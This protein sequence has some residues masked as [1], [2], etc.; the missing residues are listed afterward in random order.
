MGPA[1]CFGFN[2]HQPDDGG[3]SRNRSSGKEQW[4][5]SA[6][7]AWGFASSARSKNCGKGQGLSPISNDAKSK[8][9]PPERT[10]KP[11][12]AILP[13]AGQ[14]NAE[15]LAY[16]IVED[17]ITG[18]TQYRWLSVIARS[19]SCAHKGWTLDIRKVGRELGAHYVLEGSVRQ[20]EDRMRVTARLIDFADGTQLWA[21]RFDSSATGL[22]EKQDQITTN[23]I[24]AVGSKLERLEIERIDHNWT[25]SLNSNQIYLRGMGHLYRWNRDSIDDALVSFRKA[26]ALDPDL[27]PAYGMAAYCH[28]QR[29]SYGWHSDRTQESAECA[30]LARTAAALATNDPITLAR[31]AHAISA[32]VGDLDEGAILIEQALRLNSNLSTAWYVSAWIKLFLGSPKVAMEH[33]GR[34][35]SLNPYDPLAFKTRAAFAYSHFFAGRYDEAAAIALNALNARPGYLTAMRCA[36]A[37]Y[38]LAGRLEVAQRLIAD[39]HDRDPK[40]RIS[41]LLTLLPFSREPDFARWTDGLQSGDC[42]TDLHPF[43]SRSSYGQKCPT[44]NEPDSRFGSQSG[45]RASGWVS[46]SKAAVVLRETVALAQQPKL[47]K[48]AN[49]PVEQPTKFVLV[50]NSKTAKV[51]GLDL[52]PTILALADEVIE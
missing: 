43:Q 50:I 17:I 20:I 23:V 22:F 49:L 6:F 51:L 25:D 13:F 45:Q 3:G 30:R 52:P 34:A 9:S 41:N 27:A 33:A 1:N 24:G 31:A 40:L 2:N 4:F 5:T 42:P 38:A 47:A 37:S 48:P 28:V 8:C 21:G 26:I 18:L 19:M 46:V 36:A 39:M 14:S 35:I 32:V 15:E 12:I 11:V 44:T 29:Q 16:G 7:P 10:A